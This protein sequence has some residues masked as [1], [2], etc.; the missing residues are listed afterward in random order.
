MPSIFNDSDGRYLGFDGQIHAMSA[1]HQIYANFSGWDI[2]RSEI[3]LLGDDRTAAHG[4]YGAID[5]A[6][7]SAGRLDRSLA[8][9][10]S[11]H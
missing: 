10:Q 8:A 9:A 7:V 11:L 6:Y 1:G 4:R 2:Y 3:P 5:C